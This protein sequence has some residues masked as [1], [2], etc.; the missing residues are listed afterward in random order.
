MFWGLSYLGVTGGSEALASTMIW[1]F[2]MNDG[3]EG[4]ASTIAS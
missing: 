2:T 1:G 3:S 4:S